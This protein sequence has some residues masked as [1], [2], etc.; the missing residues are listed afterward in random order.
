VYDGATL[1]LEATIASGNTVEFYSFV[2]KTYQ[3][4][5]VAK[6]GS[7]KSEESD[8]VNWALTAAFL[9]TP[10]EYCEQVVTSGANSVIFDW[11]NQCRR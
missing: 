11:K 9:N 3:V 6:A 1:K 7:A 4:C 2:D 8:K 5:V 10:S